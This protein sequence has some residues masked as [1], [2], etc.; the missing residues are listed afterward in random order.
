MKTVSPSPSP[1][2]D[3]STGSGSGSRVVQRIFTNT[4]ERCRQQNVNGAFADLRQLVPTH[5]P[6][7]KLSK[8]EVLRLAL[9]YIHFLDGLLTDQDLGQVPRGRAESLELSPRS[10]CDSW[11][12]EQDCGG[13][14]RYL[15]LEPGC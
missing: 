7:R 9:R 6:D 8:N 13:L 12:E 15:H 5:P 11:A 4:R 10:S 3:G 14:G 1:T 2:S